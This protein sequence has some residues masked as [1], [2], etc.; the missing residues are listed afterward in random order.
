MK[1]RHIVLFE[2]AMAQFDP[3]LGGLIK[4]VNRMRIRRNQVEY[5]SSENPEVTT[6]EVVRDLGQAAAA[7]DL[8][9]KVL[10]QLDEF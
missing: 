9:E 6:A 3:P 8:V 10:P 2:A 5:A 7:I 4:P 1:G